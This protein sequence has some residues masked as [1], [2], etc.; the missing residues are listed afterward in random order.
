MRV[1]SNCFEEFR[2]VRYARTPLGVGFCRGG[3]K[4]LQKVLRNVAESLDRGGHAWYFHLPPLRQEK[5][6][7]V[8]AVFDNWITELT[9]KI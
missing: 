4:V 5:Q 6:L 9:F 8:I 3:V 1:V 2:R 7:Q